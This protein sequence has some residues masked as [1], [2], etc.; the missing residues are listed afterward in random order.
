[1]RLFALVA[2]GALLLR[3]ACL[4]QTPQTATALIEASIVNADANAKEAL[5]YTFHEDDANLVADTTGEPPRPTLPESQ[6]GISPYMVNGEYRWSVQYDVLFVEGIPYRRVVGINGQPLSPKIAAWESER[7]DHAVATIHALSPEQRQQRLRAPEGMA[8]IMTDPK[9]L[10]SSYDCKITGHEKVEK[11]P[12]TVIHCKPRHDLPQTDTA[13][14]GSVTLWV[15]DQQPF[16]H[17]TRMV[18][19]H[20]VGRYGAGTVVTFTWSLL[21]GVWHQTS[22]ELAWVGAEK[23]VK[24]VNA[25][26]LPG[27]RVDIEQVSQGRVV[28][29]FSNFK[30]FR[31]ESR[32][33]TPD[34]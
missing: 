23:P 18:L 3:G 24:N 15:D 22:T 27:A 29:T 13:V 5:S 34:S 14:N 25:P 28:N 19:D 6:L 8:S 31:I 12:A 7:Y 21:D 30:K 1:M 9:Q 32:I 26:T 33:V 10:T 16:F 17:R 11:R 20:A 2:G 4:A